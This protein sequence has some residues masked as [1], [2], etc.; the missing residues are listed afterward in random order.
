MVETL[1]GKCL[2]LVQASEVGARDGH[3]TDSQLSVLE[4]NESRFVNVDT[5]TT[6]S[7][8]QRAID[9]GLTMAGLADVIVSSFF[10]GCCIIKVGHLLYYVTL[11]KEQR[12]CIIIE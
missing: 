8:I 7:G 5:T 11:S 12:Q 2:R 10:R 9:L 3:D 6:V 4:V 1:L